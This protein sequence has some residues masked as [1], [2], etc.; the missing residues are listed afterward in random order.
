MLTGL[1]ATANGI[2]VLIPSL[3]AIS[4]FFCGR[5]EMAGRSGTTTGGPSF[6]VRS[7][8]HASSGDATF[9]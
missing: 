9:N 8:R 4:C 7:Q 5:T 3:S 1:F 6:C 2:S